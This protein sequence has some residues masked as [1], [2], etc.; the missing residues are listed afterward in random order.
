MQVPYK[1]VYSSDARART[2]WSVIRW[3]NGVW[4]PVY[5]AT[6]NHSRSA[7]EMIHRMTQAY[8]WSIARPAALAA[9]QQGESARRS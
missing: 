9:T 3:D 7:S 1:L 5:G 6:A 8:N 4:V 2:V